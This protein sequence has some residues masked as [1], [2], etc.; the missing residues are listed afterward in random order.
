MD[1]DKNTTNNNR[2]MAACGPDC[3]ALSLL[4]IDGGRSLADGSSL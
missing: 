4:M 3:V 1:L 2:T